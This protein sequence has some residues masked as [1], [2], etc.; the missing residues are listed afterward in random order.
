[1]EEMSWLALGT[2]MPKVRFSVCRASVMA[3]VPSWMVHCSWQASTLSPMKPWPAPLYSR[4][5][6][7]CPACA[8]RACPEQ[9]GSVQRG[10][11][12]RLSRRVAQLVTRLRWNKWQSEAVCWFAAS[13]EAAAAD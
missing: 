8:V 1:M 3:W 11:G 13:L 7:C 4:T 5:S 12:Y 9:A 6:T 2:G 10:A